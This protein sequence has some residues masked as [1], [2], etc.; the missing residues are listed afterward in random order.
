MKKI[1]FFLTLLVIV[2]LTS[3]KQGKQSCDSNE[4]SHCE[5]TEIL[6]PDKNKKVVVARL[7]VKEGQEKAFINVASSLVEATRQEEGNLFYSLYQS[8][9][10]P[11]EFIF[12]EE[13]KD[14]AAFKVHASSAHFAA[15]QEGV[16]DLI[17]GDLQV[18]EF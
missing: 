5:A 2:G 8:P 7:M 18:D 11:V 16:K 15:F 10:N 17:S 4:K 13:Y 9:I 14:D 3:C 1:G 6:Q 12:Y